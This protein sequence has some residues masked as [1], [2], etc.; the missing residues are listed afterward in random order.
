MKNKKQIEGKKLEEKLRKRKFMLD[1]Q[2][3]F[4]PESIE[5][6]K[7]FSEALLR[8]SHELFDKI[9]NIKRNFDLQIRSKDYSCLIDEQYFI[10]GNIVMVGVVYIFR[11]FYN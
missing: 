10:C 6:I 5:K 4:T 3:H 7:D 11:R 2:F 1:K 9:N 8:K